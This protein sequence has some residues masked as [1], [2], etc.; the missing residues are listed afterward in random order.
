MDDGDDD[1]EWEVDDKDVD[2]NKEDDNDD[3]SN[4]KG[5]LNPLIQIS[6]KKG[7]KSQ[8]GEWDLLLLSASG[9]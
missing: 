3:D 6:H 9:I 2:D 4:E 5:L 8:W 7:I 1:K